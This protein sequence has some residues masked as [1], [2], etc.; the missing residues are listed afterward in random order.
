MRIISGKLKG[1]KISYTNSSITRPLRD[2]VR[3]NIFNIIAHSTN[4]DLNL[5]N[6]RV[7][8]LYS[9]VGSFGIECLSRGAKNVIFVE[10]DSLAFSILEE[11][12]NDLKL[13]DRAVLISQDIGRYIENFKEREKFDLIFLDPPYKDNSYLEIISL[14]KEKKI[15]NKNHK[16]IIHREKSSEDDLSK[17]LKI[18]LLKN[19]G[20]SKIIFGYF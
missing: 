16:V 18:E 14:I 17:I 19:Y 13:N 6:L 8:D 7:L 4:L 20:R 5:Y 3:E 10:K 9:G 1:K 11:N 2:Y 15:L 12:V